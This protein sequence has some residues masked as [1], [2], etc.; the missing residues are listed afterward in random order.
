MSVDTL[1]LIAALAVCG[2]LAW[3]A[4]RIE[5]HWVSKDGERFTCRVQRLGQDAPQGRWREMRGHV[6]GNSV[7]LATR[8]LIPNSMSG[9][10]SVEV[11]SPNPP[12]RRALWLLEAERQRVVLRIPESSRAVPRIDA[13]TR[14]S[15]SPP[16]PGT[17]PPVHPPGRG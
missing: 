12:K 7:V 6:D 16:A 10:Y 17:S 1:W 3:V 11:R 8:G 15:P 14:L 9:R 13:L 5:P 4:L 2:L